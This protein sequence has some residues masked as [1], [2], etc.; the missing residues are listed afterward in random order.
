MRNG[1]YAANVTPFREDEAFSLDVD[2]YRR[3]VAWLAGQGVAGVAP[4]GTNGEGPSTS[5]EEKIEVLEALVEDDLGIDIVP[6]LAEGN[7]VDTLRLLRRVN[8]LPVGGVLVLPPYYFRPVAEHGLRVL[9]RARPGGLASP[10]CS[11]TTFPGTRS[12]SRPTSSTNAL[13]FA[14]YFSVQGG[15]YGTLDLLHLRKEEELER[16]KVLR[17]RTVVDSLTR[18][19]AAIEHD[20]RVQERVAREQFGMLRRGSFCIGWSRRIAGRGE[21]R[22]RPITVLRSPFTVLGSLA[23]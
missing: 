7:L 23:G 22:R 5:V 14:L 21:R 12:R 8:E 18:A 6:V 11:P 15:E 16:S 9:V 17:L 2:A 19:A 4:F 1:V 3:H 13:A 10:R 20:P